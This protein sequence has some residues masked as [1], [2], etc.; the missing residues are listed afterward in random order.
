VAQDIRAEIRVG[1][2]YKLI[3]RVFKFSGVQ[4]PIK[5]WHEAISKLIPFIRFPPEM[6]LWGLKNLKKYV[7][8]WKPGGII[9]TSMVEITP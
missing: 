6:N 1:L 5:T 9:E 2:G 8:W 4:L 3:S 7:F